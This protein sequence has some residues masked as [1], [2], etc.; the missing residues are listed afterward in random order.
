MRK[1]C[2]S[3]SEDIPRDNSLIN[4][5]GSSG[6]MEAAL[7]LKLLIQINDLFKGVDIKEMVSDDDS[8]MR[9]HLKTKQTVANY[10]NQSNVRFFWRIQAT[11]S[12]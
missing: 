7:A 11:I 5:E 4:W 9:A 8:T 1:K 12:K 3:S 6:A 10:L 2:A